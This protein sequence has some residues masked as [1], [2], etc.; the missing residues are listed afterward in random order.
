MVIV[1]NGMTSETGGGTLTLHIA[2]Q[3][4]MCGCKYKSVQQQALARTKE[5]FWIW[6]TTRREGLVQTKGHQHAC[7]E[8]CGAC[9]S[10]SHRHMV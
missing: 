8:A 7:R 3:R 6:F 1:Q 4:I 10:L 9:P 5:Y 2:G